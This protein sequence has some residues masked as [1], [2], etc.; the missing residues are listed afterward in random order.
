MKTTIDLDTPAGRQA[1]WRLEHLATGDRD[2][3][4]QD[5]ATHIEVGDWRVERFIGFQRFVSMS[6]GSFEITD[7]R[8]DSP[9]E[10][11]IT[12][13]AADGREW[14]WNC[15]VNKEEP[16]RIAQPWIVLV[17]MEP[18]GEV[19]PGVPLVHC[20]DHFFVPLAELRPAFV[21]FTET[22][23]LPI[24]WPAFID[25]DGTGNGGG[26]ELGGVRL[27]FLNY[28]TFERGT[29]ST[30]ARVQGI[31]FEPG[32][33]DDALVSEIDRRG[34]PH[35]EPQRVPMWTT[36]DFG[37]LVKDPTSGVFLCRYHDPATRDRAAR[38]A[39]LDARGGGELGVTGVVEL[40]IGST[41]RQARVSRWQKLLDPIAPIEPGYW[42]V[43]DGPTIR[44]VEDA[45]DAVREIVLGVRSVD[46]ASARVRELGAGTAEPVDDGVL[47]DLP[48]LNGLVIRLVER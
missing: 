2:L 19:G 27:E 45:D 26:V 46:R 17:D 22:L 32:P 1:R 29:P 43:G 8:I 44:I 4:A 24:A 15:R 6:I 12:F 28:L 35:E 37:G 25:D 30:P 3:T 16:H 20:V 36:L 40:V 42:H 38:K 7:V 31:A 13:T 41:D 5:V 33:I 48:A 14:S 11:A 10:V 34:I 39:A 18:P 21:L 23:G 9:Y 47:L